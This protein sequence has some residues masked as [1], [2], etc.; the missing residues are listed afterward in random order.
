MTYKAAYHGGTA[1]TEVKRSRFIASVYPVSSEQEATERIASVR[2]QYRDARH[3]CYAFT[4][5]AQFEL[6]RSSDDG[7]PSGTAGHP[8]LEL[9][10]TEQIHNTLIVVTRYFGGTLLGTGGLV[11]AYRE[12]ARQ[13]LAA[14][15]LIERRTGRQMTV[16]C[17]YG[18]IGRL[19]FLAAETGIP[20]IETRYTDVVELDVIV[21]E[22]RET[23]FLETV[24]EQT[25]ATAQIA[26]GDCIEYAEADGEILLFP[27]KD[28][29]CP[30][31][32]SDF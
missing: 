32:A 3:N 8:I 7:E 22:G 29:A 14:S 1:E 9:L 19:Q 4:I 13:G 6:Q 24:T 5:G 17:D 2:R 25:G 12:A 10:L 11:R 16:R 15:L 20:V 31:G 27:A 21:P 23:V 18:S 30:K 28:D 26:R